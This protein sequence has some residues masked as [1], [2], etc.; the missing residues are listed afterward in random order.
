[1]KN[2]KVGGEQQVNPAGVYLV[3]CHSVV[4]LTH[5]KIESVIRKIMRNSELRIAVQLCVCVCF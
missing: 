1:M 4:V 5:N 2:Y 3:R